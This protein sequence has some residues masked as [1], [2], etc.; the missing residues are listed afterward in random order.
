M[1]SFRLT[2]IHNECSPRVLILA[3]PDGCST[4]RKVQLSGRV[5][6]RGGLSLPLRV[7]GGTHQGEGAK[8]TQSRYRLPENLVTHVCFSDPNSF[9]SP[10]A[11]CDESAE[12]GGGCA[13]PPLSEA[14]GTLSTQ[15]IYPGATL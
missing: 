3:A 9:P 2:C 15:E 7:S 14:E 13:V 8:A 6:R 11:G 4:G 1:G 10:P 5:L 12:H